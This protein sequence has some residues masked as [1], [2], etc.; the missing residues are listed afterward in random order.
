[1][2]PGE[3]DF[4]LDPRHR[5]RQARRRGGLAH[6]DQAPLVPSDDRR[7]A[8]RPQPRRRRRAQARGGRLRR[9]APRQPRLPRPGRPRGR[10]GRLR[11]RAHAD[12]QLVPGPVDPHGGADPADRAAEVPRR[13]PPRLPL[14]DARGA[15]GG[16]VPADLRRAA[17]AE[18]RRRRRRHRAAAL[19][20][21]P[22]EGRALRAG[23][24][25][26]A[27]LPRGVGRRAVRLRGRARPRRGRARARRARAAADLHRRLVAGGDRGRRAAGRRVPDVGRAAGAGR[28]EARPRARGGGARRA[29]GALRHPPARDRARH[30]GGGVGRGR[31]AAGGPGPRGDREGAGEARRVAVRGAAADGRAARAAAPTRSRSRR[32]CGRASASCAAARGPRSSAATRR[33]PTASRST[34]TLGIDEF[35]LSGYPHLEEAYRVGEGVLPVLRRRGLLEPAAAPVE[36]ALS[37]VG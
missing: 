34:T 2:L 4:A 17:A 19:R 14:A 8:Q 31:P 3:V 26:P 28:R 37:A 29:R 13:V 10:A 7:L 5:R 1:M 15:D 6:G 9:A 32:T 23:G 30:V 22:H 20:R 12:Q 35:I 16:D 36:P 18:R 27:G 21:L 25:V 33:S 24:R 11:G